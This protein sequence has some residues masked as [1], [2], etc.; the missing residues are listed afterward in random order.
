MADLAAERLSVGTARLAY[1]AALRD[2]RTA[3]A[4]ADFRR[5]EN[6][7]FPVFDE[8]Q[9][10][11]LFAEIQGLQPALDAASAAVD[12]AKAAHDAA[13][14]AYR[15]AARRTPLFVGNNTDPVL[16]LPV[17]VEAIYF[18]DE[19]SPELR[20]RVY[21]DDVHVDS[22]EPA[23]TA[24]ERD[25]AMA[26]W[27][28]LRAA[29]DDAAQ[30]H[31]AWQ[32]LVG[33]SGGDRAAWV[34]EALTP[35]D[36]PPGELR[37]PEVELRAEAWT[38]AAHTELLPDHFEFSA[39]RDGALVWRMPGKPIP[40]R[41]AVGIAPQL[42]GM[43]AD[44]PAFDDESRWLVE[45]ELA[46]KRGMALTVPLADPN[47][48]FDLLTVVG[49]GT[50][51]APTGA[52]RVN[53]MLAAHAYSRGLTPLPVR[54]PT[55]NTPG[56]RSGWRPREAPTDP[57]VVAGRRAA[58]DPD[59]DQEAARLARSL[60]IDGTTVLASVCDPAGGEE[61]LLR[62][63]QALQAAYYA[64]SPALLT[65]RHLEVTGPIAEPWYRAVAEHY[66][67]FVRAR[68]PLP[69]LRIGRQPYGLLPVSSTYL[70]QADDVDERI[71][72]FVRSFF[73][74]FVEGIGT[75]LQVGEEGDQDAVLLDLL[76]REASPR[77]ARSYE[78]FE[79]P[80]NVTD[81]KP[82]PSTVG[83]IPATSALAWLH[84]DG[85]DP[86]DPEDDPGE[87][88]D[89][90]PDVVPETVQQI[91][92]E[93]P[94]AQIL[95]L[96]DE[97]LKHMRERHVA[98]NPV[99]FDAAFRP[100]SDRLGQLLAAPTVSLFYRQ[101]ESVY[102]GLG[103]MFLQGP[104]LP[105]AIARDAERAAPVRNLLAM[106]VPFED[107]ASADLPAFERLFR[108][109]LEPLS[110][111]I[112]AWVTS[113]ATAR[114]AG[115]RKER[116]GGIRTGAYGWLMDVEPGDPNPSREGYVV[117]PSLQHATTA[118]VLRSGWQAHTDRRAFAV[119]VQSA[120]VRRAL[121]MV[122]GVREGQTVGALLGYQFERALH[123]AGLDRFI[124]GLRKEYPLAPLVD[125]DATDSGDAQV[126]IGA[127]NVVDGQAL[128]RDRQ[129]LDDAA[130]LRVA[131][132]A[133]LREDAP[134]LRRMLGELDET[135][136]A[137][138]DLLLAE[139]VHHLVG[140]NPLR[141]GLAADAAGRGQ[142]LPREFDVL[143]T[144]RGGIG[145][146]HHVGILLPDSLPQG[147]ADERPLAKLEPRLEAWVRHRL[148]PA[149]DW[150]LGA[151]LADLG[152]C[153]LDLLIA[154]ADA[155][156]GALGGAGE[157]DEAALARLMLVCERLRAA[158]S[159]AAP[160][161]PTHLDPADPAPISGYD[162]D[163]LHGR[164]A[165]WTEAVRSANADLG[166]ARTAEAAQP[167]L[168]RLGALGLPVG[169]AGDVDR[170]RALLSG[171]DLSGQTA[172]PEA[173]ERPREADAWLAGVL[174][175]TGRLL[176]PAIK[177]APKL[178]R[179]LPPAPRPGVEEDAVTEWLL[180][181]TLVRPRVEAL[182]GAAVAAETVAGTPAA[183]YVVAQPIVDDEGARPW[184]ATAPPA[185]G[186]RPRCSL[187]MQR[188]GAGGDPCGLVVDSWTEVV[189]RAPGRH[190]PEEV[191]GVAFDYDRPGARAPQGLLIAVPPDPERGWCM[192]DLHACLDEALMLSRTRTLD[193]HDLPELRTVLPIP[194]GS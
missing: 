153:A 102:R 7:N 76:S 139:S 190:G 87:R 67:R 23:L 34:R 161:T 180:D 140:G 151:P 160:L 122:E 48:R 101:V 49:V 82:P 166:D 89:P 98:P 86:D 138:A 33:A 128:R 69:P 50:Q 145:V 154:P 185:E 83:A 16:L 149:S 156:R 77:S 147:W 120:R 109:T 111:R 123:D 119:D 9:D 99:A 158:L 157:L 36:S 110:H 183:A 127:R 135:F 164:V 10:P 132:G 14:E 25:A 59:G 133:D 100:L 173:A 113:L 81:R 118:A 114:L 58:Y 94:L 38:R 51:D 44:T 107:D 70:W 57:D 74:R 126:A 45:F 53:G 6:G 11:E 165:A 116:P 121:A 20:I 142:D 168:Q 95:V 71:T 179:D 155:L 66:T 80:V 144:P 188:D 131:A 189:P 184:I 5:D 2:L 8:G 65:A 159:M 106:F 17:R 60:G 171:V 187:V 24:G 84:Y 115:L 93:H 134:A 78:P 174:S 56:S 175:T 92:I 21:P 26:Y 163:E 192:E 129:K 12:S 181:M 169:L 150:R 108:E 162:L 186:P 90:F 43:E 137:V 15:A 170:V 75:A 40:D 62:R 146:T 167:I 27:R 104:A 19:G 105:D 22:H 55:N 28:A 18:D 54:T 125:P 88:V 37:F 124:E 3:E 29:G 130:A 13:V 41:L 143:R 35:L 97:N 172:P 176:H 4:H 73:A 117:T 46:A 31:A 96:F 63:M 32:A 177:I 68:G 112:D 193:L 1:E 42:A 79:F 141:A 85:R 182:D 178:L 61:A 47:E 72:R 52:E 148:G 194:D 103:N 91:A 152:W 136:D 39:Y 30:R 64:W 191:V